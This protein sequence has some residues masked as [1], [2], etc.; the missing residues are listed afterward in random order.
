MVQFEMIAALNN[1]SERTKA[2]ELATS[3][4]KTALWVLTD[5]SDDT[6]YDFQTL[7]SALST[8]FEPEDQAE[9]FKAQ[10]RNRRRKKTE[11]IP[12]LG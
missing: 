5:L 4:R 2:L 12:E 1:W 3:L 11:S 8:R 9:M 10:L 6:R 7:V